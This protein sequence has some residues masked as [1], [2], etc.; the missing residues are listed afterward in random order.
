MRKDRRKTWYTGSFEYHKKCGF[1]KKVGR[2]GFYDGMKYLE[3]A[4]YFDSSSNEHVV[5]LNGNAHTFR[6]HTRQDDPDTVYG[7]I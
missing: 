6:P 4:L 2:A 1:V 5:M 3:R 7:F